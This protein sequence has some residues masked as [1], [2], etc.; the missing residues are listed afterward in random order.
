MIG[1]SLPRFVGI[2][3]A[4]ISTPRLLVFDQWP[5]PTAVVHLASRSRNVCVRK[6]NI[7]VGY[8]QSNSSKMPGK[9]KRVC[10]VGSGNW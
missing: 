8:N 7:G 5:T 3:T 10:I 2:G 1:L 9:P 4:L 6:L